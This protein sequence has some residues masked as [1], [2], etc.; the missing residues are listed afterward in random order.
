[1]TPYFLTCCATDFYQ[2]SFLHRTAR[3]E[4]PFDIPLLISELGWFNGSHRDT[5]D[6]SKTSCD[7]VT[8]NTL[9][10][11]R[12]LFTMSLSTASAPTFLLEIDFVRECKV[13]STV[14]LLSAWPTYRQVGQ[15]LD[16]DVLTKPVSA[17]G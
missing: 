16:V 12:V 9:L 14:C 11:E 7:V 2:G 4:P 15:L 8:T 10:L 6:D 5:N 13:V 3:C 1:M 17:V